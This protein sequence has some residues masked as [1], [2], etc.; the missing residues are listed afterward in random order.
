MFAHSS[1]ILHILNTPRMSTS[2]FAPRVGGLETLA[3]TSEVAVSHATH[4]DEEM[5][6]EKKHHRV[7]VS[8]LSLQS[9]PLPRSGSARMSVRSHR[10]SPS[11][12]DQPPETSQ[13]STRKR[14]RPNPKKGRFVET[15]ESKIFTKADRVK[16]TKIS[17]DEYWRIILLRSIKA[18]CGSP[19]PCLPLLKESPL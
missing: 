9:L 11:L 4:D 14:A 10:A 6:E 18:G 2:D 13:S 16:T 1:A 3:T 17:Q 19:S 15:E 7:T 5:L 12:D 8:N